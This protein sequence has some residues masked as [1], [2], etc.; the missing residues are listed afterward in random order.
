MPGADPGS[1]DAL[2]AVRR[3]REAQRIVVTY[4]PGRRQRRRLGFLVAVV[5]AGLVGFWLGDA[6]LLLQLKDRYRLSQKAGLL[7]AEVLDFRARAAALEQE[8]VLERQSAELLRRTIFDLQEQVVG[9]QE[10]INFYQGLMAPEA[11]ERGLGVRLMEFL[12]T[13][14]GRVYDYRLV[15]QQLTGAH[16]MVSGKAQFLVQGRLDGDPLQLD[17]SEL[18]TGEHLDGQPF[19]FRYFQVLDGRITLPAGF[20]PETVLVRLRPSGR[21]AKLLEQKL[22]W[23]LKEGG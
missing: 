17:W 1:F 14:S 10:E 13:E 16:P 23:R 21:N 12:P 4:D 5:A 8:V 11:R 22:A 9:L 15:L 2:I 6:Q 20:L 18:A 7:Q 19:G 3:H